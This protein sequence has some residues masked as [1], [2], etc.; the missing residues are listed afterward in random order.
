MVT[1]PDSVRRAVE[2]RAGGRCEYCR[3]PQQVFN[4]PLHVEHIIPRSRGGA[5]DLANLALSCSACNLAKGTAT[6]GID[7]G[8]GETVRLFN[9][10]LDRWDQHFAWAADRVTLTGLTAIGAATVSRLNMN[11]PLQTAARPLWH[12]LGLFP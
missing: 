1:V 11:Q 2:R 9:P 7:P 10:R 4:A 5:D 6:S 3:A 8:S 12:R